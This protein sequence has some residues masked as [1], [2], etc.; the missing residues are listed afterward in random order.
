MGL[1]WGKGDEQQKFFRVFQR[2]NW[3]ERPSTNNGWVRICTLPLRCVSG[4]E[5][6][7]STTF[8][9]ICWFFSVAFL[10]VSLCY[11]Q[12]FNSSK[13][14]ISSY[15][16]INYFLL[17]QQVSTEGILKNLTP[18]CQRHLIIFKLHKIPLPPQYQDVVKSLISPYNK[19][20]TSKTHKRGFLIY[21][22]QL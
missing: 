21:K 5:Q 2:V 20:D 6:M 19:A 16:T 4:W 10:I 7:V 1:C 17:Q 22:R 11:R 14:P 18:M 12:A 13:S 3:N 8:T 15:K 9:T